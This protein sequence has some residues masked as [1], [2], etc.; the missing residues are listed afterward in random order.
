M[1]DD[2][3]AVVV[4]VTEIVGVT[5]D[6]FHLSV[7]PIIDAVILGDALTSRRCG[8]TIVERVC[9]AGNCLPLQV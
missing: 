3:V 6:E 5:L 7:K 8:R 2:T 1:S 4:K 9:K